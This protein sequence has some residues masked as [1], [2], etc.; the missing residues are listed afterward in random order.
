ME[1]FRELLARISAHDKEIQ[2][3]KKAGEDAVQKK[4]SQMKRVLRREAE[5]KKTSDE[6]K[7]IIKNL[8]SIWK[9]RRIGQKYIRRQDQ[10]R[11]LKLLE[12]AMK[13][14]E[15]PAELYQSTT[16]LIKE[17]MEFPRKRLI[18]LV[19]NYVH[20]RRMKEIQ[21]NVQRM[22]LESNVDERVLQ[23]MKDAEERVIRQRD[24]WRLKKEQFVK[25]RADILEKLHQVLTQV[26]EETGILLTK[27]MD[28]VPRLEDIKEDVKEISDADIL[29]AVNIPKERAKL[30]KAQLQTQAAVKEPPISS[31]DGTGVTREDNQATTWRVMSGFPHAMI[32]T[33]KLLD[34][35]I[36][37]NLV[38]AQDILSRLSQG[39]L[40]KKSVSLPPSGFFPSLYGYY[41]RPGEVIRKSR[42]EPTPKQKKVTKGFRS[43]VR[44]LPPIATL[45]PEDEKEDIA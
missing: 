14:N 39:S 34:L 20:Y 9:S 1:R 7:T 2:S 33:P 36:N 5:I 42:S 6:Q 16:K 41:K 22:K 37:R 25:E 29:E 11:N 24:A 19:K 30:R 15:I 10:Q 13:A 40:D 26:H 28:L 38:A 43:K 8:A 27:P 32:T 3:A 21:D 12:E 31:V 4:D 18:E 44:F 17:A 23:A 35:D 45:Y